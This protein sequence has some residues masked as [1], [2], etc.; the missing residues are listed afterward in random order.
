MNDVT[1]FLDIATAINKLT[2]ANAQPTPGYSRPSAAQYS[3]AT[4][5]EQAIGQLA[6]MLQSDPS[7]IG[8]GAVPGQGIPLL[9]GLESS[10][11]GTN[12]YQALTNNILNSV[13]RIN[14]GANM[15]ASEEAFY[16]KTYLPQP[17]DPP[18]TVQQKIANLMSFFQPILNYPGASNNGSASD[19]ISALG[20]ASQ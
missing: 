2:S 13:A 17:G 15:P 3:Q 5:A 9:G 1:Q 19:L 12:Q 6:Q 16:R 18:A 8:K 14:T 11:L 4:T 7:L 10:L 20:G